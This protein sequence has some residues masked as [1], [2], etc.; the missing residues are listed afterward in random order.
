MRKIITRTNNGK[1]AYQLDEIREF[2]AR[3]A[4]ELLE[5]YPDVDYFDLE[6]Q[7]D[8]A[9]GHQYALAMMREIL[10]HQNAYPVQIGDT[11]KIIGTVN[12]NGTEVECIPIGKY[13]TVIAINEKEECVCVKCHNSYPFWYH[14]KDIEPLKED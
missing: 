8:S 11:V 12:C 4:A 2:A 3:V 10:E 9:F 1:F 5:K 14:M 7:F 6:K 13:A